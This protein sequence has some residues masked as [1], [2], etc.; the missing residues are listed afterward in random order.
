MLPT[1]LAVEVA[2]LAQVGSDPQGHGDLDRG[3]DGESGG[4]RR[5]GVAEGDAD[6]EGEG[7]IA[8][9]YDTARAEH[10]RVDPREEGVRGVGSAAAYGLVDRA[11]PPGHREAGLSGDGHGGEAEL[12]RERSWPPP[13]RGCGFDAATLYAYSLLQPA[14]AACVR[15]VFPVLGSPVGVA[16]EATVCAQMLQT[17]ARGDNLVLED[18]LRDWSGELRRR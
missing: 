10:R 17:V 6:G 1:T 2:G 8:D 16:A 11:A 7:G 12:G 3:E 5:Q 4:H 15:D 9:G 18:Q 13:G 14:V